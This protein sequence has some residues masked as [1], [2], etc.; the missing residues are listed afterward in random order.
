MSLTSLLSRIT[1][2]RTIGVVVD[3]RWI[4]L[5]VTAATPLG[6]REIFHDVRECEGPESSEALLEEM[7]R[8]W[9]GRGLARR[10]GV[11]PWVQLG[12]P[13]SKVFQAVVPITRANRG[14]SAY[15]LFLEAAASVNVRSEERIYDLLKFE[16]NKRTMACVSSCVR[17]VVADLAETL[18]RL[19]ARLAGA[20]P[21]PASLL[22]AGIL[23]RKTP[24]GSKLCLRAFLNE[25]KGL[26]MLAVGNHVL[27]WHN[28][29]LPPAGETAAILA[30]CSTLRLMARSGRMSV[31]VD[32]VI[33]HGRPELELAPEPFRQRI[34]ALSAALRGAGLQPGRGRPGRG[35]GQPPG[36]PRRA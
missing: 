24:R 26:A 12:V 17:G 7:L 11:E 29:D 3:D 22:R 27:F 21:A 20:E 14:A 2:G 25:E 15:N 33:V 36:R 10:K 30:V 32:T 18:G 13:E 16:L 4:A 5:S 35:A 1:W 8:P 34:G 31:P 28:F 6:R 9:I 19:G 23:R